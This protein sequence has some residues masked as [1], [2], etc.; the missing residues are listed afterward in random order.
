MLPCIVIDFS[1]NNQPDALIISILFCYK[2]LYVL[3]IFSASRQEFSTVHSTLVSF[4]QVFDDHFHAD[5][6]W[7]CGS[8]LTA[9]DYCA[10]Q[11]KS[12]NVIQLIF[13]F[14][15]RDTARAVSPWRIT[16]KAR[17]RNQVNP[18]EIYGRQSGTEAGFSPS[19]SVLPCQ[20]YSTISPY[21]S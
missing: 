21:L 19:T 12:Q 14:K 16:A 2:T 10:V 1:S 18:C 6:G 9:S 7:N 4:M 13:V 20:Y 11:T 8:I 17:V 3:G 5:S 15:G